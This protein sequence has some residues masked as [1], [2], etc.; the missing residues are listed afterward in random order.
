[1]VRG[2]EAETIR[3]EVYDISGRLVWEGESLGNELPW[4]TEGIDGL[5]LANGVYIYRVYVEVNGDWIASGIQ[6]LVILR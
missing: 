1:V 2:V 4:H 5:P 6:K 3:V